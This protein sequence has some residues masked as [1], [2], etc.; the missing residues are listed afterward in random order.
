MLA[1]RSDGA[2]CGAARV[3]CSALAVE[4]TEDQ[5]YQLNPPAPAEPLTASISAA[6]REAS[7]ANL[8]EA[9][10]SAGLPCN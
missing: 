8:L 4:F 3:D 9:A 5:I 6:Q 1:L 2:S 7:R 10:A